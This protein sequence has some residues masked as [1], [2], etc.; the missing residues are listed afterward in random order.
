MTC[1]LGDVR[2]AAVLEQLF[3]KAAGS[4]APIEAVIHFAGLKLR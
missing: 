4:G 1:V 2:D 3:A